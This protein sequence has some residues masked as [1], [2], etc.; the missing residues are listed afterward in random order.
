MR[1]WREPFDLSLIT[2]PPPLISNAFVSSRIQDRR[3]STVPERRS[4]EAM[5]DLP[6]EQEKRSAAETAGAAPA[7]RIVRLRR[8]EL[9]DGL[10]SR[11]GCSSWRW[12]EAS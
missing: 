3:A 2:V 6:A 12:S 10:A 1:V 4:G 7:P 5:T 8:R 9:R 11:L